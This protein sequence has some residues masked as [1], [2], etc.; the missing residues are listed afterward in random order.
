MGL[1]VLDIAGIFSLFF[2]SLSSHGANILEMGLLKKTSA[3]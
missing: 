3:T 1:L 2:F